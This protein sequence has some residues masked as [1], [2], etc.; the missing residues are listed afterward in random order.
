ME[1]YERRKMLEQYKI[2]TEE[3]W[4]NTREERV[5]KWRQFS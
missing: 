1:E 2:L 4:E 3:E 5:Q